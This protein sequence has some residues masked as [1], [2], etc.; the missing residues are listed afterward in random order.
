LVYGSGLLTT[1]WLT[2]NSTTLEIVAEYPRMN[3]LKHG[4]GVECFV[5]CSH[6]ISGEAPS[7]HVEH[8]DEHPG[9]IICKTCNQIA[10]PLENIRD[11][12]PVCALCAA[13]EGWSRTGVQ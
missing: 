5:V 11:F 7:F 10:R 12:A 1:R 13:D 9:L 2:V 8:P 6:V 3:C 4:D